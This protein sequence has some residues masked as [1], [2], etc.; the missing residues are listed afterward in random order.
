V[1]GSPC[2]FIF[3]E[4]ELQNNKANSRIRVLTRIKFEG[5]KEGSEKL[6]SVQKR[7]QGGNFL[8]KR[9]YGLWPILS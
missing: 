2:D 7:N 3:P 1:Q 9:L 8:V 6:E 5:K 4:F